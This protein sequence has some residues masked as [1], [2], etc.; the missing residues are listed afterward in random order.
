METV[1]LL[2]GDGDDVM[3]D[4]L[5]SAFLEVWTDVGSNTSNQAT[6]SS[7]PPKIDAGGT[8]ENTFKCS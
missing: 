1:L 8:K 3:E 2:Q 4:P 7:P 6:S 5:R